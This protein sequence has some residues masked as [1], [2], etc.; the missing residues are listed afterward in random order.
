MKM[1][2]IHLIFGLM[3]VVVVYAGL[4]V[5]QN[6]ALIA[7]NERTMSIAQGKVKPKEK[8]PIDSNRLVVMR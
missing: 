4:A 8:D 7:I 6:R 3:S 5:K 2:L 1:V